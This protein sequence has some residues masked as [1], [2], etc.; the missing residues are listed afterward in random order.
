MAYLITTLNPDIFKNIPGRVQVVTKSPGR[1][2]G[3]SQ[4]LLCRDIIGFLTSSF[5]RSRRVPPG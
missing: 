4:A 3:T 2:A 5:V 1:V